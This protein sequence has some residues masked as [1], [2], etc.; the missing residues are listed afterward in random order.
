MFSGNRNLQEPKC[1]FASSHVQL[2]KLLVF[3]VTTGFW[4]LS[5]PWRWQQSKLKCNKA[6]V[7]TAIYVFFCLFNKHSLLL[8]LLSHFS[9]IRL[10]AT[11]WTAACQAPPSMGFS[12][13]EYWSGVPLPSP[14]YSLDWYKLLINFQS[15]KN[16]DHENIFCQ[17]SCCHYRGKNNSEVLTLPFSLMSLNLH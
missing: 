3:T 6:L 11:P 10:C 2:F 17:L 14:K 1:F 15:S 9:R 5:L 4:L 13:Q 16:V 7:L 8:L 12:R